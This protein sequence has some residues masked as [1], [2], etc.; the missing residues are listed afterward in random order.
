MNKSKN[1]QAYFTACYKFIN[2]LCTGFFTP[3]C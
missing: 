3:L 1:V 2:K